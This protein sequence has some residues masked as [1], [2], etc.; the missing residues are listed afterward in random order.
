MFFLKKNIRQAIFSNSVQNQNQNLSPLRR[1]R[2]E[3]TSFRNLPI[4]LSNAFAFASAI[5]F[6][7]SISTGRFFR[8]VSNAL[9]RSIV[10]L[11]LPIETAFTH[12]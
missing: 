3:L 11:K 5:L 10:L 1:A 2:K 4:S 8:S 6:N 7:S 9:I 12:A